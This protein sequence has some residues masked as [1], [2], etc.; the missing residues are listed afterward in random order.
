MEEPAGKVGNGKVGAGLTNNLPTP[1]ATFKV[2]H[3]PK[4]LL[5]TYRLVDRIVC[6]NKAQGWR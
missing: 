4:N 2:N 1:G 3:K 5:S 6:S